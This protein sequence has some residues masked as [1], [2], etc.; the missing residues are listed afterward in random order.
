MKRILFLLIFAMLANISQAVMPV[1][2]TTGAMGGTIKGIVKD[3]DL[4]TAVEYATVSVFRMAD[5]SLVNGTITN[6][7]GEFEL[8]QLKPGKYYAEI[9]FIGYNKKTI[10]NIPISKDQK[11]ADLKE[12][13]LSQASEALGEVTVS[14]ERL[15]IQYQIDKKVI[16]V[17]RQLTTA[18][19]NA[20]D[21]LESVP[22]INVDIEGN[23]SLR[24]SS[25]FTVL[26]DGRPSILEAADILTQMPASVIENIEIITNP[27]AKYDPEGSSGIINIITKKGN[28]KGTS[29]VVNLNVGNFGNY[30]ADFLVNL[31]KNKFNFHLGMD[32]SNR[33]FSGSSESENRTTT[34][35]K[36]TYV[37]SEGDSDR[38]RLGYGLRTGFDYEIDDKNL[39]TLGLRYGGREMDMG[40][41]LDYTDYFTLDGGAPSL[42]KYYKSTDNWN[43]EMEF[44][45]ANFSYQRNFKGKGHQLLTQVNYSYRDGDEKSKTERKQDETIVDGK[46][47]TEKGPGSHLDIKADYT[48]PLKGKSK[49]EAGYQAQLRQSEDITTQSDYN[50]DSSRYV[51]QAEYG[52]EVD[53][54]KNVHGVYALYADQVGKF[55]YQL[56]LRSEYTDR[57]IKFKGETESFTINRWDFFPTIHTQIDLKE[58]NQLMA[59]YTRRIQRPR[60]WNLEPFITW[61][62]A[63][64]VRKGN[65]SLKP[66][67][68][69]S[70]ELGYQKRMGEQS[71]S[72]ETY[73][74]VTHNVME[75]IRSVYQDNVMLSTTENV[76]TDY[77]LGVETMVNLSF[78]KWFKNDLIGNIFHY[79]E[80]GEYST[81]NSE[82]VATVQDFSTESLNWSLRNNSTFMFNKTTRFQVNVIYNSASKKAQG[83]RKGF[84]TANLGLKKDFMQRKLSATL[85]LRNILNTA[86]HENISEGNGFYNYSKFDMQWPSI[87]LNLSYKINNYKK[88]RGAN[89]EGGDMEEFEM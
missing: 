29:G 3:K 54:K 25:S 19:G 38:E 77:S 2:N 36:T 41:N 4:K 68:I 63:Y 89:G 80:K 87:K 5:S 76:G 75:R 30:G 33:N 88:K 27:S 55:G 39:I 46:K 73:Y 61:S 86:K 69:D 48:L 35:N 43:R 9:S 6:D 32:Y 82:N 51:L 65:P 7:K 79:K 11:V 12:V 52:H 71:I 67:Y 31:R 28:L 58:G 50:I 59:S 10:R 83:E 56:G 24:G 22:S 53:Y 34:D 1:P 21:V 14:A 78:A 16:P 70:Y 45:N 57:E 64:N 49:F 60:G 72:F 42:K 18:S 15:P 40:S 47:G 37:F 44:Y 85:Q 20:V 62:D 17:S 84:I 26:V 8:K 13:L 81:Y 66:E 23:V 74:R